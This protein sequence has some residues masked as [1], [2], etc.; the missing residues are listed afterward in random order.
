MLWGPQKGTLLGGFIIGQM[1]F[2]LRPWT[3]IKETPT[4][5]TFLSLSFNIHCHG[6]LC[7]IRLWPLRASYGLQSW[8]ILCFGPFFLKFFPILLQEL[9]THC[10]KTSKMCIVQ[11]NHWRP[12]GPQQEAIEFQQINPYFMYHLKPPRCNSMP[13]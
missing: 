2:Q 7:C 12:D 3:F 9:I 4:W 11:G 5:C 8:K 10:I 1:D 6:T 13:E